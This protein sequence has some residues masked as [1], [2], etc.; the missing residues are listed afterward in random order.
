MDR[1]TVKTRQKIEAGLMQLLESRHLNQVTVSALC[2]LVKINRSTFYRNYHD[3]YDVYEQMERRLTEQ[4]LRESDLRKARDELLRL[5]YHHQTFYREFF[6][7]QL[8]SKYIK[9]TVR[10]IYRQMK[11]D[12][13][14]V[15]NNPNL[16]ISYQYNYY[17]FLGVIKEWL[18]R[19][20]PESL[21]QL[22][23]VL[24]QIIDRQYGL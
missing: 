15:K 3:T 6:Y 2:Q 9:Q 8:E 5:I 17:G 12:P 21:Q 19:G 22:G 14:L 24:Y 20:C 11:G 13:E 18:D 10:Q 16:V 4:F 23:A 7:S 1:R